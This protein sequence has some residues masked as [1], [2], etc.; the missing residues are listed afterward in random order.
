MSST[1]AANII[2]EMAA[3]GGACAAIA[4]KSSIL[5]NKGLARQGTCP[6]MARMY[7]YIVC[8]SPTVG[9]KSYAQAYV[10]RGS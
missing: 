1:L 2:T 6:E 4:D 9:F 10:C 8:K 7:M 5:R 3:A